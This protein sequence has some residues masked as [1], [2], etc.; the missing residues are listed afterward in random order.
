MAPSRLMRLSATSM[1]SIRDLDYTD[2]WGR[3]LPLL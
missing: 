1:L 3:A 2:L